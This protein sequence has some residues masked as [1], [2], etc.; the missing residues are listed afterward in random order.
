MF[1]PRRKKRGFRFSLL[2]LILPQGIEIFAAIA[3]ASFIRKSILNR[4]YLVLL[5]FL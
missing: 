3:G 5:N 1:K 2:F 4:N